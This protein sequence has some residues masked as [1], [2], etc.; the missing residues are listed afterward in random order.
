MTILSTLLGHTQHAMTDKYN[1]DRGLSKG[2]WRYLT[3]AP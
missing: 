1:D 3:I 2:H